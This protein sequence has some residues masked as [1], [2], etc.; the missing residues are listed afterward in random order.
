[1]K[2]KIII[3]LAFALITAVNASAADGAPEEEVFID[4]EEMDKKGQF[5]SS[6]A[7]SELTPEQKAEAD[8]NWKTALENFKTIP[9][10]RHKSELKVTE[11]NLSEINQRLEKEEA[12]LSKLQK[13]KTLMGSW[14]TC[15]MPSWLSSP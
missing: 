7:A 9:Q 12:E 14:W 6:V 1:M 10:Y 8:K 5:D 15:R 2:T 13:Q 3:I 4:V 11:E